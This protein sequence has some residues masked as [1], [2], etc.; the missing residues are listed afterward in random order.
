LQHHQWPY[1]RYFPVRFPISSLFFPQHLQ[2]I[3]TWMQFVASSLRWKIR[4]LVCWCFC[5][6]FPKLAFLFF[7]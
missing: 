1:V 3:H 2:A 6:H 4:S 5:S 7:L